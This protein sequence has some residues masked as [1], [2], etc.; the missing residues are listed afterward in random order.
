MSGWSILSV[1]KPILN[2]RELLW[3]KQF[4]CDHKTAV[5]SDLLYIYNSPPQEFSSFK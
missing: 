4:V 2:P 3:N 1:M 5:S